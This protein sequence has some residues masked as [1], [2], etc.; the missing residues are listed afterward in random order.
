MIRVRI[1][2]VLGR[3]ATLLLLAVAMS[4][5]FRSGSA[6][7]VPLR[8]TT[9]FEAEWKRYV[10]L[11]GRKAMAVAGDRT[12]RYVMGYGYAYPIQAMATAE[13]LETC[14]ERRLDQRMGGECRIYATGEEVVTPA[15]DAPP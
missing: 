8:T 13:A 6:I 3:A 12:G 7:G 2:V 4:A 14:E 9:R 10:D 5:C 1:S 15:L 11:P